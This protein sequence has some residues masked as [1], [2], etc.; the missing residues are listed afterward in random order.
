MK[1]TLSILLAAVLL[2]GLLTACGSKTDPNVGVYKL[3]SMSGITVEEFAEMMGEDVETAKDFMSV[4]LKA[5]G[6]ATFVSDGEPA[7]VTW[8]LE[9]DKLTLTADGDT[10]E[11]T[12][13]DGK[14]TLGLEGEELVL[15]KVG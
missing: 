10:L 13:K 9:G 11:G 1:R 4:E 2:L 5:D 15:A 8:K 7:E 6:K 3:E 12:L 14:I